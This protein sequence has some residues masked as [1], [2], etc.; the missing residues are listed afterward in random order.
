MKQGCGFP[1]RSLGSSRHLQHQTPTHDGCELHQLPASLRSSYSDVMASSH[2]EQHPQDHIQME[3]G[4][5]AMNSDQ[6][7]VALP[8][9]VLKT[10]LSSADPFAETAELRCSEVAIAATTP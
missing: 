1:H 10:L 9:S 5:V 8:H 6:G 3:E 2:T 7:Q 4:V